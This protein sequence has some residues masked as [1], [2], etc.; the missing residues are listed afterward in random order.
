MAAFAGSPLSPRICSESPHSAIHVEMYMPQ[1]RSLRGLCRRSLRLAPMSAPARFL[2]PPQKNTCCHSP[3]RPPALGS[4][5]GWGYFGGDE[6]SAKLVFGSR[7]PAV[8]GNPNRS[9]LITDASRVAHYR[10]SF[11]VPSTKPV[12]GWDT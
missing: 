11:T 9:I 5:T 12:P 6:C 4:W 7:A 10:L 2:L 8:C 1:H 3:A